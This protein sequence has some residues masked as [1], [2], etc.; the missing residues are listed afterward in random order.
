[1]T[2]CMG[3]ELL[4]TIDNPQVL[5]VVCQTE[6]DKQGI[7]G[8]IY[9]NLYKII[10]YSRSLL[11]N[12]ATILAI[13]DLDLFRIGRRRKMENRDIIISK[14]IIGESIWNDYPIFPNLYFQG[15]IV[16]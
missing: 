2:F 4:F 15:K 10:R 6:I 14:T 7:K 5:F 9:K 11:G 12:I 8:V 13:V 3:Y 16:E 1:M